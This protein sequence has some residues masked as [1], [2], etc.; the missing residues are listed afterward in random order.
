MRLLAFALSALFVIQVPSGVD[1]SPQ[2]P[3]ATEQDKRVESL[4]SEVK[5]LRGEVEQLRAR[6]SALESAIAPRPMEAADQVVK[7]L[8]L[9]SN[10]ASAEILKQADQLRKEIEAGVSEADSLEIQGGRREGKLS[11]Q[12]KQADALREKL[13]WQEAELRRLEQQIAKPGMIACAWNGAR[14]VILEV[15]EDECGALRRCSAGDFV[16]WKG[17]VIASSPSIERVAV[18]ALKKVDSPV[19]FA[20]RLGLEC[21][22]DDEANVDAK[23]PGLGYDVHGE[24]GAPRASSQESALSGRQTASRPIPPA[25]AFWLVELPTRMS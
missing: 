14:F 11:P 19:G 6:L 10:E 24:I 22:S 1:S 3:P 23:P 15:P 16:Q 13:K 18:N 8:E 2:Q 7:L 25:S 5:S 9:R 4:E 20:D 21:P 12:H 17:D